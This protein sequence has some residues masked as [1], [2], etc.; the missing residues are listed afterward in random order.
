[1]QKLPDD[2]SLSSWMVILSACRL[3]GNVD[4]AKEAIEFII[5]LEP[6]KETAY[7]LLSN[8]YA[9]EEGKN[10]KKQ[11][12]WAGSMPHVYR[13]SFADLFLEVGL[14]HFRI[15]IIPRESNTVCIEICENKSWKR[16]KNGGKAEGP[17][18]ASAWCISNH[19]VQ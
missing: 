16:I 7:V 2:P 8:I 10:K 11:W 9:V 18:S 4:V 15:R 6:Q 14:W 1:M 5:K 12:P 17:Y 19:D 3:H 13:D